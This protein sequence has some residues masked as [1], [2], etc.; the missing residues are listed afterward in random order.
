MQRSGNNRLEK[1]LT[2]KQRTTRTKEAVS[3]VLQSFAAP[4]ALN[5]LYEFIKMSL[6]KT[7]FSTIFRIVRQLEA[8][9]KVIQIDWRERGSR[10]EWAE[11]PHHH[12]IVCSQCGTVEDLDDS[13]LNFDDRKVTSKTGYQVEHHSIEL[14]GL[15]PKCQR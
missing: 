12:H 10:Y 4:I 6:P 11:L 2:P 13:I 5:E 9:G 1:G 7:A 3:Q 15:C 8:E 14:Q